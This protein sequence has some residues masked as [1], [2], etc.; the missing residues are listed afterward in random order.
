[1]H[2]TSRACWVL[3]LPTTIR[4]GQRDDPPRLRP[5]AGRSSDPQRLGPWVIR[6]PV[7]CVDWVLATHN[8]LKRTAA[9]EISRHGTGA[10]IE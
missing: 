1:M 5:V 7:L 3:E 10:G 9:P 6:A 8:P 2:V 4:A